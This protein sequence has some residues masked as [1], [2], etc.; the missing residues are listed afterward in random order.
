MLVYATHQRNPVERELEVGE[1]HQQEV[2]KV[3]G[4]RRPV[5]LQDAD[6][7]MYIVADQES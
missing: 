2:R 7:D 5:G 6:G 1:D 4:K 3:V